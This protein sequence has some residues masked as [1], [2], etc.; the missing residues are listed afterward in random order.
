MWDLVRLQKFISSKNL[1]SSGISS[2]DV[3]FQLFNGESDVLKRLAVEVPA[4]LV[5]ES[6]VVVDPL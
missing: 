6:E 4:K 3:S 5:I 1:L 2:G